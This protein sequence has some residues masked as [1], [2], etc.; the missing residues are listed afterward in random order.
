MRKKIVYVSVALC[1]I[2][3]IVL[4]AAFATDLCGDAPGTGTPG[5][6]K[7]HQEE[8]GIMW[9]PI[10]GIYY[11]INLA[12]DLMNRPTSKDKRLTLFSSLVAAKLNVH[13]GNPGF[14]VAW[15]IG[16]ANEWLGAVTPGLNEI[17][18]NDAW[19]QNGGEFYHKVLDAYNNG[20]LCAPS[21]DACE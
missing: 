16:K 5:Y 11:P 3:L 4:Q 19:W 7:N 1:G 2:F 17:P 15:F 18:A 9:I 13:H 10:G 8:W 21:R 12:I 20:L 6:W 14:C